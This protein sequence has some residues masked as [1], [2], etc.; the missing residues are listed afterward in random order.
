MI[1]ILILAAISITM[2]A[3][4]NNI[5]KRAVDAKERTERAEIIESAKTDILGQIAE[6]KG[7]NITESQFKETLEKYF[8]KESIPDEFPNDLSSLKLNSLKGNYEIL[9]S[10]IYN[11]NL[12][13]LGPGLYYSGTDKLYMSWEDMTKTTSTIIGVTDN[14]VLS[15]RSFDIGDIKV[16]MIIAN[17]VTSI[18]SLAGIPQ[19]EEIVIP[20]SVISVNSNAFTSC[21]SLKE[22][23]L[24]E[25][26]TIT[27]SGKIY[28]SD[29]NNLEK[30]TI[31][32]SG[33]IGAGCF[34]ENL[35]L[36]SVKLGKNI[37]SIDTR[38]FYGCKNLNEIEIEIGEKG[39]SELTSIGDNAFSGSGIKQILLPDSVKTIRTGCI[40]WM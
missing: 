28:F 37:K 38:A 26:T 10:E 18:S 9:A 16:K 27:G 14:G 31:L 29:C 11:G 40:L 34:S 32:S 25:N 35:K 13:A 39:K 2:I 15:R 8:T 20:S 4:D 3:G 22:I 7:E 6:N 19:L 5:L 36:T 21:S 12:R 24:G 1:V 30:A 33:G 17:D 23:F